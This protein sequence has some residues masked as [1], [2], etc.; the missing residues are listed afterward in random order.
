MTVYLGC[1]TD[2]DNPNGLKVLHVDAAARRMDVVAE[3]FVSNA[4]YQALS[5]DGGVLY[6]C[7][8]DGLASFEVV[9]NG[10]R[11]TGAEED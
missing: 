8:R 1:Y 3:Y 11:G 10:E 5:P 9:R 2:C 4:L 6:S 7:T